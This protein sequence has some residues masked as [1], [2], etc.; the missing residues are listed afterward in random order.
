MVQS[1]REVVQ[2][3]AAVQGFR[4]LR[5]KRH[6]NLV[7]TRIQTPARNHCFLRPLHVL[8]LDI[9]PKPC[10]MPPLLYTAYVATHEMSVPPGAVSEDIVPRFQ[11][12][13]RNV[14]F[15]Q[16]FVRQ[17]QCSTP[18]AFQVGHAS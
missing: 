9:L 5:C 1:A 2:L 8:P 14:T 17:C 12:S 3:P 18:D 16:V 7:S 10:E 4:N 13:R 6:Q 15:L 11:T